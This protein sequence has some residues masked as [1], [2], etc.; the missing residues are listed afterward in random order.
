MP[1]LFHLLQDS[2]AEISQATT[3]TW[4]QGKGPGSKNRP[5][6]AL[7]SGSASAVLS[8]SF[9]AH[10]RNLR[11]EKL[12]GP[13]E[14]CLAKWRSMGVPVISSIAQLPR[15]LTSAEDTP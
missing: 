2:G 14:A 8:P 13:V 3:G 6:I 4:K 12:N 10:F 7:G 15:L 9:R 11:F 5:A 1:L